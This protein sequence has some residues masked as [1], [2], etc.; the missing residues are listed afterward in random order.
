MLFDGNGAP[1]TLK[2]QVKSIGTV[3]KDAGGSVLGAVKQA[4]ADELAQ[5]SARLSSQFTDK[6]GNAR[7]QAKAKMG[8]SFAGMAVLGFALF[9]VYKR[10]RL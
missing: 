3:V 4:T 8:M 6:E 1:R 2:E 9:W 10:V 7:D 5:I